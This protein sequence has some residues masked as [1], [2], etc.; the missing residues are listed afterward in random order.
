MPTLKAP[1]EVAAVGVGVAAVAA[2][3][4]ARK[5]LQATCAAGLRA[6]PA[7]PMPVLAPRSPMVPAAAVQSAA[8]M[9]FLANIAAVAVMRDGAK[10][11]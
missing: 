7:A 9:P 3:P 8:L 1:Q 11:N 10:D 2:D 5:R 4:E 6:S